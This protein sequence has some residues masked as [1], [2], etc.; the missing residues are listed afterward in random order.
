MKSDNMTL[1]IVKG[2]FKYAVEFEDIREHLQ[3]NQLQS[4]ILQ[5][6]RDLYTLDQ[7][8]LAIKVFKDLVMFIIPS[9]MSFILT[10]ALARDEVINITNI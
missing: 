9:R 4:L 2:L 6:Q 1:A 8:Q 10:G 7:C 3:Q 5:K